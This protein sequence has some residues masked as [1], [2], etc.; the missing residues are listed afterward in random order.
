MA[1]PFLRNTEA[2]RGKKMLV[3]AKKPWR[4]SADSDLD[5]PCLHPG[6]AQWVVLTVKGGRKNRVHLKVNSCP[7]FHFTSGETTS[8]WEA[9]SLGHRSLASLTP[10]PVL[11]APWGPKWE[12][13]ACFTQD[14]SQ[15]AL[16]AHCFSFWKQVFF[17]YLEPLILHWPHQSFLVFILI[18][19]FCCTVSIRLC[20]H[21]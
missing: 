17:F 21:Q 4:R 3:Q 12:V 14:L 7:T 2:Q 10:S 18:I 8:S 13:R 9:T 11:P 16:L 1:A 6:P 5:L 19:R 20:F 15:L